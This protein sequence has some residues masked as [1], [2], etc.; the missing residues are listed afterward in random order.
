MCLLRNVSVKIDVNV[1]EKRPNQ[2][3]RC[4]TPTQAAERKVF[5]TRLLHTKKLIETSEKN[6]ETVVAQEIQF[7]ARNEAKT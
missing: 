5:L 1:K 2:F 7:E 3:L 4:G 6:S